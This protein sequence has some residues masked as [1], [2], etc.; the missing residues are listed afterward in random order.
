MKGPILFLFNFFCVVLIYKAFAHIIVLFPMV[1][2]MSHSNLPNSR[3]C[4][5]FPRDTAKKVDFYFSL[6]IILALSLNREAVYSLVGTFIMNFSNGHPPYP[7]L[8]LNV[9][10]IPNGYERF[11]CFLLFS[12]HY[13]LRLENRPAL[14]SFVATFIQ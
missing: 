8:V 9:A 2:W 1:F 7:S 3:T 10:R 13:F 5:K 14:V 6:T 12:C 4:L 11:A